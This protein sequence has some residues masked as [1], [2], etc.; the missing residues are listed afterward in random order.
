[1]ISTPAGKLR[2]LFTKLCPD[3]IHVH[4]SSAILCSALS[5]LRKQ[6]C[7]TWCTF[8]GLGFPLRHGIMGKALK[9]VEPRAAA[10]FD[11]IEV[12]TDDDHSSLQKLL[13]GKRVMRQ[14]GYGFG[15]DD[16]FIDTPLPTIA[17]REQARARLGLDND[18]FVWI[19][20]GRFV[21]FKGFDLVVRAF[22]EAGRSDLKMKLMVL[23][24]FDSVHPSG[25][26]GVELNRFHTDTR[27]I[28]AGWQTNVLPWLDCSD[29]MVFPSAREG[30][31][32][33]VMEALARRL[34]VVAR[35]TRGCANLPVT[36]LC[37]CYLHHGSIQEVVNATRRVRDEAANRCEPYEF[38]LA[39][40]RRSKWIS[41]TRYVYKKSCIIKL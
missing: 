34:P 15:C 4:F 25:L 39:N 35:H 37:G 12:L 1:M 7:C 11:R 28:R 6:D 24:E 41:Y 20:V 19:F 9:I 2:T 3:I 23:G 29:V 27:I 14:P 33:S 17:S 36:E 26:T 8:Q 10:A 5:G 22:W 38:D 32:V 18:D 40:L 21:A 16:R 30:M 13:P 31:P